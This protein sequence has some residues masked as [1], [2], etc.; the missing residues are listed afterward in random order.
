MSYKLNS[1]AITGEAFYNDK[2]DAVVDILSE[3]GLL[4]ESEG[5]QVVNLE[6]M[7]LNTQLLSRSL[8]AQ[9]YTSHVT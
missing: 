4:V 8:T 9:L 1:T 5:A 3:K 7:E 2:M 6:N